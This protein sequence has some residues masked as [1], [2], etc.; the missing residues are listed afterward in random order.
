MMKSLWEKITIPADR[1]IDAQE[2]VNSKLL[3]ALLVIFF[4]VGIFVSTIPYLLGSE[5]ALSDDLDFIII[6][7]SSLFWA[8]A[9]GLNR[10]GYFKASIAFSI[11][12]AII[13][14]FTEVILD[15]DLEDLTYLLL[16]LL[17]I[18]A[19]FS[20][21]YVLFALASSLAGII[22][23]PFLFPRFSIEDVLSSSVAF[24]SFGGLLLIITKVHV[25]NAEK[26]RKRQ[27]EASEL[28]YALITEAA[29]D[30][31]WDWDLKTNEVYYS[32]RW[33]EMLGYEDD[34]I[35]DTPEEW[36]KLIHPDDISI[37][38]QHL[39]FILNK[40]DPTFK[41][42]YR[43]KHKKGHY[44]W[45]LT[46]GRAVLDDTGIPSR[47]VGSHSDITSRKEA[48]KRLQHD[49][50]HDALT[51]LS[52]R[53][54]LLD[55]LQHSIH[56]SARDENYKYAVLFLDLD[57][58]KDINDTLGHD[59]GDQILIECAKRI[60]AC[61]RSVDTVAR[62]G[63]DEFVVL[64]E[65]FDSSNGPVIIAERILEELLR[66]SDIFQI[67]FP[68]TASI[69]I[70]FG[71]SAYSTPNAILKDA[72]IAMYQAKETG[73]AKY[74]I[75]DSI[76]GQKVT[77][78]I[79]RERELAQAIQNKNF[80]LTYQ[81]IV[82]LETGEILSMEA[83]I[84]WHHPLRGIIQPDDFIPVAEECGLILEIGNWVLAEACKQIKTWDQSFPQAKKLS[85]SVN[86]SGKQIASPDFCNFL[87][88]TL[89][90]TDLEAKRLHLEITENTIVE[91]VEQALRTLTEISALGVELHL[92]DFGTG[93]SSI[94][95]LH[96]FPI[97]AL[98]IDKSFID[99]LLDKNKGQALVGGIIH[100]A[101][102]LDLNVVAEGI[103]YSDQLALLKELKCGQGQGFYA[104]K[105]M[106][107]ED[108]ELILAKEGNIFDLDKE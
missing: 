19:F 86:I 21:K 34:E 48:E 17:I 73:R 37:S 15:S 55:R 26:R 5:L 84:R 23:L 29:N 4:P 22:L 36:T 62:L 8:I 103:E 32:P 93:Y 78:R 43:L 77:E 83:L 9:Y 96:R 11:S 44:I 68:L 95:Y 80:K 91:D 60:K 24:M 92:D 53:V 81:P 90:E 98:K 10:S 85:I 52:N 58:F 7:G 74:A 67:E 66:P 69:G 105:P 3:S 35:G 50:L 6:T 59:V 87:I 97:K 75:F 107:K 108:M 99:R 27:L 30:G 40:E 16:P 106:Y 64:L 56:Y 102:V 1:L 61:A 12:I 79:E 47:T 82:S 31:L 49:A 45:V 89:Q 41:F 13:I 63:G 88:H 70:V 94:A 46:R 57:K 65:K 54:L 71:N 72:D 20:L 39:A 28:R 18:S 38:T 101:N 104:A 76:M 51:G 25:A 100:L 2:R 42:E 33:K 14:I